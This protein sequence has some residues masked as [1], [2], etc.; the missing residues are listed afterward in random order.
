MI[1]ITNELNHETSFIGYYKNQFS[2]NQINKFKKFCKNQDD[3]KCGESGWGSKIPRLQKWYQKDGINF[4][5]KWKTDFPRWR[6]HL[7]CS[8]LDIIQNSVANKCQDL[9]NKP[10]KFNSCLINLYRNEHD[11]IKPHYDSDDIFG[12]TP[13]ICLLS[14]GET[15]KIE[16]TRKKYNHLN[17]KSLKRDNNASHLDFS[18]E[19]DEGSLLIMDLST[20]KYYMHGI[21]KSIQKKQPRFSMTFREFIF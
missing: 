14:L 21:P 6:A 2:I 12:E 3:Y 8:E 7:Y 13:L 10:V 4:S 5:H 9:L 18:L 17:K 20:Q 16:F 11:S 1:T 15:R 19:L